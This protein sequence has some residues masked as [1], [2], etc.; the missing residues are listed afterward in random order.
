[1]SA[2]SNEKRA[3][4]EKRAAL[5]TDL[6]RA[7]RLFIAGAAFTASGLRKSWVCIRPIFN[8]SMCWNFWDR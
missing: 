8:S 1:M 6:N 2:L 5:Q 4:N 3:D 7:V